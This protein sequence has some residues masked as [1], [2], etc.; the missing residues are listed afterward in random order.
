MLLDLGAQSFTIQEKP[1][2]IMFSWGTDIQ[3][4]SQQ[5]IK[6]NFLDTIQGPYMGDLQNPST[7]LSNLSII[8]LKGCFLAQ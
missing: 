5:L 8:Q 3:V 2:Y 6:P 7:P 1:A 4:F